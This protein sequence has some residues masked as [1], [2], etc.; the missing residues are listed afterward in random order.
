MELQLKSKRRASNVLA[1]FILLALLSLVAFFVWR[2]LYSDSR[3]DQT[4][5]PAAPA[6]DQLA[7]G[8]G[9]VNLG[10]LSVVY[11]LELWLVERLADTTSTASPTN[12]DDPDN[13]DVPQSYLQFR[14]LSDLSVGA[15]LHPGDETFRLLQPFDDLSPTAQS[16]LSTLMSS[17]TVTP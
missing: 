15:T 11:D 3:A 4:P 7:P 5:P 12:P 17:L 9:R 14:L 10:E 2:A 13:P 1:F 8:Q 6:T 16:A